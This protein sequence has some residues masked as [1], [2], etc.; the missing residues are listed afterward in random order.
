MCRVKK[1]G[2]YQGVIYC[3]SVI[4]FHCTLV[5]GISFTPRPKV[6]QCLQP[7]LTQP[8]ELIHILWNPLIVIFIKVGMSVL[9]VRTEIHLC[10]NVNNDFHWPLFMKLNKCLIYFCEHLVSRSLSKS[11]TEYTKRGQN[12][13]YALTENRTCM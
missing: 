2:V 13:I 6:R 4:L 9:K 5:N 8:T 7:I 1:D 11:D 12:S 10:R 3:Q